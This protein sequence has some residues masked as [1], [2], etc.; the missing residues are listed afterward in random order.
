MA[1]VRAVGVL[2]FFTAFY[3]CGITQHTSPPE[4]PSVWNRVANRQIKLVGYFLP[5]ALMQ[6]LHWIHR[7]GTADARRMWTTEVRRRC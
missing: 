6:L 1:R 4:S 3:V 5:F 2:C 7:S